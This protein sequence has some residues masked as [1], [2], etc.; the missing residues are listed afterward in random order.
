MMMMMIMIL[1]KMISVLWCARIHSFHPLFY[2]QIAS[3]V[4]YQV[5][6]RYCKS[7]CF[8][9]TWSLHHK[10]RSWSVRL[11]LYRRVT[12]GEPINILLW[13]VVLQKYEEWSFHFSYHSDRTR[14]VLTILHSY[15]PKTE[16]YY[17]NTDRR[18]NISI[19]PSTKTHFTVTKFP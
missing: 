9:G 6:S 7:R 14:E 16:R 13:Y 8:G 3:W 19:W 2:F 12:T 4:W 1:M 10:G 11:F 17:I 5:I 15:I 18:E